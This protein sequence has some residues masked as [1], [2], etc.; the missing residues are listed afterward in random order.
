MHPLKSFRG[1]LFVVAI[2]AL[3]IALVDFRG[4]RQERRWLGYA[5]PQ[6]IVFNY[7]TTA[8]LILRAPART[9][10]RKHVWFQLASLLFGTAVIILELLT[11]GLVAWWLNLLPLR[12]LNTP[13]IIAVLGATFVFDVYVAGR[14]SSWARG[15]P[16]GSPSDSSGH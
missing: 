14:I 15:D 4:R 8:G 3:E 5:V 12:R 6:L 7:F 13:V 1:I 2:A 16:V 9:D 11:T 10:V